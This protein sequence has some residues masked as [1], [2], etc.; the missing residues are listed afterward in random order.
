MATLQTSTIALQK[1][2]LT[3]FQILSTMNIKW[4]SLSSIFILLGSTLFGQSYTNKIHIE[5]KEDKNSIQEISAQ[6]KNM[7]LQYGVTIKPTFQFSASEA[8]KLSENAIKIKGNDDA[9]Q[10]LKYLYTITV[11]IPNDPQLIMESLRNNES[12]SSVEREQ[13]MPKPPADIAPTTPSYH[14]MQGYARADSGINATYAWSK[15]IFGQ[16]VTVYNVEYGVNLA[17]EKLV[18]QNAHIIDSMTISSSLSVDFTEHGTATFGVV[19]ADKFDYGNIGLMHGIES[20]TLVPESTREHGYNR[21]LAVQ[22]AIAAANPGDIIMYEMQ[23]GVEGTQEYVPADYA[24]A[25]W[26]ATEAA[27]DAGIIIVAAA[28]N[29]NVDL[30][31]DIRLDNYR[32]RGD[33]GSIIVGAGSSDMLH[34]ILSFST[35]GSRVNLQGWGQYVITTGYG[36]YSEI[37]DDFNQAYTLFSGTSSATPIVTSAVI[38]VQSYYHSKTN[39]YLTGP[40]IREILMNTGTPQTDPQLGHIGPIPNIKK[41]FDVVDSMT[42]STSIKNIETSKIQLFPNPANNA[43]SVK[44]E[45]DIK[46]KQVYIFDIAGKLMYGKDNLEQ[47]IDISHLPSGQ[48]QLLILSQERKTYHTNFIKN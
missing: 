45:Q 33:N 17:H 46:V 37:G 42:A 9:F 19:F 10:R 2:Y 27:V 38:A 43:I 29:G 40:Q 5:F 44:M 26:R 18:D 21:L 16:N 41:A 39:Q 48:Y 31:A 3:L 22:K 8:K 11:P 28:G 12:F 36:N 25:I 32:A 7:E 35:Y 15:G 24:N 14:R 47:Q 23:T 1:Y 20:L 6:L 34:K 13:Y 4:I 30:D